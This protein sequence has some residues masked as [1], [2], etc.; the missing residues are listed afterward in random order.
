MGTA[1]KNL[2][3]GKNVRQKN[4]QGIKTIQNLCCK[5]KVWKSQSLQKYAGAKSEKLPIQV[6]SLNELTSFE[7]IQMMRPADLACS[8][9]AA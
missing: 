7:N 6:Q 8:A 9:H 5:C 2:R 3:E 1:W 4:P